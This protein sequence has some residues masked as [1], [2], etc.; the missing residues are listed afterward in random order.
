M[1]LHTP[2]LFLIYNR[3]ELTRAVLNAIRKVRPAQLFVAADGPSQIRPQDE[4]KCFDTRDLIKTIDWDCEVVT[5]FRSENLGCR[6]A[7]SSA[8]C[9]F[10]EHV[11]AG[12]ILEDDCLPSNSFFYY[13]QNLLK[14]YEKAEN[15]MA[16]SGDNFQDGRQVTS[17]SYYFSRYP[18]CWGW[19]TWRRAWD[20]YDANMEKW[21]DFRLSRQFLDIGA[22]DP[23]FMSYWTTIF[24][25]MYLGEID[26]WD[27]PWAFSCWAN[28]G[29][30]ALPVRNLVKNIGF[31]AGA[32]HTTSQCSKIGAMHAGDLE[33]PLRHPDHIER[34]VAA[35]L[36]TDRFHYNFKNISSESFLKRAL[37]KFKSCVS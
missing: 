26:T 20:N 9:W 18:H 8:I 7:I 4:E 24:N 31:G 34:H 36:Y 27:Y 12:I 1:S 32:T 19:A 33:F 11:E 13:C 5:L 6:K 10:F 28:G 17:R 15:V 2:I 25:K 14:Y 16:I 37:L 22:N 30:T 3:P 29:L 21:P 23:D 35:D